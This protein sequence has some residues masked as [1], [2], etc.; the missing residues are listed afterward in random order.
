VRQSRC[1]DADRPPAM[2]GRYGRLDQLGDSTGAAKVIQDFF[3]VGAHAADYAIIGSQSQAQS[4]D[5][6][7]CDIRDD[8]RNQRMATEAELRPEAADIF[9]RLDGLGIEENKVSKVRS[10]ER[11][12]KGAELLTA[13]RWLDEVERQQARGIAPDQPDAPPEQDYVP[14]EVMPTF[15]G[16]GGGGSGEGDR[17]TALVPRALVVDILRGKPG[18]FLLVNVRGDSMEPDFRHGD[19]ILI[20]RRDTSPAQPGPFALWDGDWGEYVVKNV[21]RARSGEVRIFSSNAKY[22]TEALPAEQ[23]RIIGRPVWFGRRL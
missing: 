14:V 12:F 2:D 8:V 9:S 20:D 15:G 21:E 3:S 22:T 16:M 4:C 1:R 10:G 6:R 19:Q 18:D 17:E 5:N 23:T 11:Q 7:D 13:R